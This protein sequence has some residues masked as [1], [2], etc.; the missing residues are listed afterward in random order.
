MVWI[1]IDIIIEKNY[2][3]EYIQ[4]WLNS[5]FLA[6]IR[7]DP[8]FHSFLNHKTLKKEMTESYA[9]YVRIKQIIDRLSNLTKSN[10]TDQTSSTTPSSTT[11][12]TSTSTTTSEFSL[13]SSTSS[14]SSSSSSTT[15]SS[16]SSSPSTSDSQPKFVLFDI[17]SGKGYTACLLSKLFPEMQIYMVD[18][19]KKMN[20]KHVDSLP[21]VEMKYFDMC[22]EGKQLKTWI[23]S[24]TEGKIGLIFGSHLC[25]IYQ[26]FS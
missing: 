8:L 23:R 17:C 5:D 13:V 3:N 18:K 19:D 26:R 21:N 22:R 4:Q 15:S 11:S 10:N 6:E 1:A 24:E 16:S 20:V 2:E 14:A 12:T 9:I 7:Q 25:V